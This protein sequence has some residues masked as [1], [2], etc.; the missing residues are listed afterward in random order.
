MLLT[1]LL[2]FGAAW[3]LA[4]GSVPQAAA[5]AVNGALL[6]YAIPSFVGWKHGC[7]D[8]LKQ[9]RDPR[10]LLAAGG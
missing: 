10:V 6:L 5:S 8:V 7:H 2:F 1:L 4:A 3:S 9:L